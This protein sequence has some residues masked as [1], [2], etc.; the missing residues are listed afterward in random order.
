MPG[1]GIGFPLKGVLDAPTLNA[2]P[3]G[4][5]VLDLGANLSQRLEAST[6]AKEKRIEKT[7]KDFEALLLHQMLTSMWRS[8]PTYGNESLAGSREEE[9]YR[10]ML[11]EAVSSS[12]AEHQSLGIAD[13]IAKDIRKHDLAEKE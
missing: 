9:L 1:D 10:D 8:V 13:I 12:L 6:E 2:R 4:N 5:A 3:S 7:A 11:N